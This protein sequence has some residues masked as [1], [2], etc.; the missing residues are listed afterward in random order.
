MFIREVKKQHGP[1]ANTFY[2]YNLVQTSRI[3]GKVKQRV[4]LYLGSNPLLR[5]K[6]NRKAILNLLKARIFKQP[7]LFPD[8]ASKDLK[9]LAESFYEKYKAKYGDDPGAGASTPPGS[10]NSE[11]HNTDVQGIEVED[12]RNFGPE[13][14]CCQVLEK[15][16][17]RECLAGVGF[18]KEAIN[19]ALIAIASRAIYGSSEY[20]TSGILARNSELNNLYD[21]EEALSH[22][23][24]YHI[25]D[26]L[27]E[28]KS[29]IDDF[30]YKRITNMFDLQDRLVIFD[31]SNTYFESA[32]ANSQIARYG[33]SKEKR[34]DAPLVVFTG[35]INQEGFIR[36]SRIY[37]GN[38]ADLTTLKDM[39][40]DMEE[41]SS[42]H[43]K[44]TIVM[45]AGIATE[46]NL[47]LIREKGYDY[48]C[49]AREQLE[50]YTVSDSDKTKVFT[51]RDKN[52]VELSI[53]QPEDKGDTW[54]YVRSQAKAHKEHSINDKLGQRFEEELESIRAS[55]FKKGGT[56][57]T[58]KVW[59]RIG[60]AKQK[61]SSVAGLYRI[62]DNQEDGKVTELK[63]EKVYKPAKADK[64]KG[65]Y[66]IRTS[67]QDPGEKQLWDIYNTIREVESTF[68]CLKRDLNIRPVFHQNDE[69]VESHVYLTILAYQ[70]VN[71][72]RYML[73]RQGIHYDWD[74]IVR[75]L[76]TQTIQTLEIPT[77]EK[78][79]HIRKP[80]KPN[81]EVKNIYD[82]T[83]CTESQPS[84]R[85]FVV[86]H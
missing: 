80:A 46:D 8:N 26:K 67:Y 77:N 75:I 20:K 81:E 38:K 1:E 58:D 76:S 71:T 60:R 45:D 16:Q 9:K 84:V 39:I 50:N 14:L 70:L 27:Y 56:K 36:H 15:L 5:D 86:Y 29:A 59:E 54:M 66:F 83:N 35:V 52:Q 73:S 74:N 72:I 33:R 7:Q 55:L 57:K 63:W 32:K 64:E 2:Q 18:S 4:I 43:S 78:T 19:K 85:K 49:V 82:A 51:D 30:L 37:E 65:I 68:R 31:I 12:V 62:T 25:A 24:L 47:S 42:S 34:N 10:D 17:L 6:E 23:Q 61:H 21:V 40:A 3:D 11:F 22:K 44:K 53:L 13:N 79:I 48:V 41:H 28:H 69:R